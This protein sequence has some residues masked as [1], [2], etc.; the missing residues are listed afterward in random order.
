MGNQVFTR[1]AAHMLIVVGPSGTGKSTLLFHLLSQR[2]S[3]VFSRS[4]TTR[5]P[6]GREKNG[7]EYDFVDVD[8]FKAK[9]DAGEFAEYASVFGN[10]YGTPH[11]MIRNNVEAGLDVVFDIDVQGA[12]QL[13]TTYPGAWCLLIAPPSMEILEQRLRARATDAPDVIERRLN[14]ARSELA[15][16][17]LFDFTI[18]NDDLHTAQNLIVTLYDAMTLRAQR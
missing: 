18:I 2:A 8:T 15:Q 6:R 17:D 13:K 11:R 9:I 10:Y 7:V 16:T 4:T 14:T 5:A 1:I 12:R 3:C